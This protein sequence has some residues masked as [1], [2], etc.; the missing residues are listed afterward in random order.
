MTEKRQIAIVLY[1]GMT[2]LDALG[3]YEVLKLLPDSEIRLVAHEPGPI[4]TDR[5]VL[6]IGATH[7]FEETP[8]PFFVLVPGS[9]ANTTSAMADK[10]LLAWLK[11]AYETSTMTTSVCSGA[12]VLA[13]AGLLEGHRATTHWWA[14]ASLRRFG[15]TV[16]P[17]C[18]V[19][20]SGKIWTAAGVSA[21]L[22]LA[23]ELLG[24][25]AGQEAAEIAQLMIEYD[26]RPPFNSGHPS[27]ATKT[28]REKASAELARLAWNPRDFISVPKILWHQAIDRSRRVIKSRA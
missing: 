7:S 28:V 10:R 25:I 3:P 6:I 16:V 27:K 2:A 15:A 5:E 19:V 24:E 20:R 1:P 9:E 18:R 26:P 13:S 14:Q 8:H 4:V 21:G 22:D 23:F 17:D 11:K 12:L